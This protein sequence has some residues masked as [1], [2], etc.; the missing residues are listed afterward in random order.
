M[1]ELEQRMNT[2]SMMMSIRDLRSSLVVVISLGILK[3]SKFAL[4]EID[5]FQ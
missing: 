4:F 1:G 2:Q 5:I 3:N